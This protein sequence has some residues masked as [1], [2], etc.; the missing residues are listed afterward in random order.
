MKSRGP[1]F[2]PHPGQQKKACTYL[3][4]QFDRK[5][6]KRSVLL[7]TKKTAKSVSLC[8][9]HRSCLGLQGELSFLFSAFSIYSLEF[10]VG[11]SVFCCVCDA[12]QVS[13]KFA[14]KTLTSMVCTKLNLGEN[15]KLFWRICML[16]SSA[17]R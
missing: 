1:G 17:E 13:T 4:V 14:V 11:R 12:T 9:G 3:I 6:Q 8:F 16:P 7:F 5:S 10:C 15:V 2:A